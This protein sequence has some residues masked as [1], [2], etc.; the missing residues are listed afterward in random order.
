MHLFRRLGALRHDLPAATLQ[1]FEVEGLAFIDKNFRD[2]GFND[3]GLN[4][5][6]KRK[7]TDIRG[8]DLTRYRTSRVGQPGQL[9]KFGRSQLDRG[10]LIGHNTG[11]DK[12]KN[13]IRAVKEGRKVRFYTYK[14]YAKVH[15]EG[16]ADIPRRQ[17]MGKSAYLD[18]RIK[19]KIKQFLNNHFRS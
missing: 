14:K 16:T 18:D 7:T 1:I 5:W 17:F 4:K 3:S 15:N 10:I 6:Q 8:R 2:Q 11:G 19:R 12:L 9:T 13:S